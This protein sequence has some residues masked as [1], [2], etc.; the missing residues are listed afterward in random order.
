MWFGPV[1]TEARKGNSAGEIV[2]G[3][4][5]TQSRA[6]GGDVDQAPRQEIC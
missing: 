6:V 2:G 4:F 5:T 3:L 1:Q